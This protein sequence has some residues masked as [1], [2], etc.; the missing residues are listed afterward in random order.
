MS[1]VRAPSL[2][3]LFNENEIQQKDLGDK[4]ETDDL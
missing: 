3:P 4:N 1:R 2:T